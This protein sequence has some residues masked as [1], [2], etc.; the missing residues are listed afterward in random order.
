MIEITLTEENLA[1]LADGKTVETDWHGTASPT[2]QITLE[3]SE[4]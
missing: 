1:E 4:S 3:E 2:V